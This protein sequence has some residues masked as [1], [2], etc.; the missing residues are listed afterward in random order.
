MGGGFGG[1]MHAVL[2]DFVKAA[3]GWLDLVAIEM[4]ERS[5]ALADRVTLFDCFRDIGFGERR[6][7]K[8]RTPSGKMRSDSAGEGAAGAVQ[9]F[10]LTLVTRERHRS[11]LQETASAL[12][13][14]LE[15]RAENVLKSGV[16][17]DTPLEVSK[18]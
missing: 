15:A 9:S 16:S 3:G 14:A 2:R 11:A 5:S 10:F 4:V 13:R 7:F 8:Q 1:G 17:K 18:V 12:R 6:S